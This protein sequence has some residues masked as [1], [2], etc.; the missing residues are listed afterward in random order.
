MVLAHPGGDE[1]DQRQPEQQVQV[2]PQDPAVDVAGGVQQVVVVVPVDAEVD[3]AQHVAQEH[4]RERAQ[5]GEVGAVRHLQLEHH[6]RDDDG[7]DA[8]A[9][10]LQPSL[11][12]ADHPT[13]GAALSFHRL[14]LGGPRGQRLVVRERGDAY[15]PGLRGEDEAATVPDRRV[16][17]PGVRRQPG[18][19]GAA[20]GL[21]GRHDAAG[22]RGR[23]QPRGD[24]LP[25]GQQR[26]V[27]DP[28]DDAHAGGR[29]VRA[30]DARFRL[31]RDE[32]ADPG[33]REVAFRSKSGPLLVAARGERLALDFPSRPGSQRT[34]NRACSRTPLGAPRPSCCAP[35]TTWRCSRPSMKN[36][37]RI[38]KKDFSF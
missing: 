17:E 11:G 5:R 22:D 6:D 26:R 34:P 19:R 14:D 7:D 13:S 1:R 9:E 16:R 18:G 28:L 10:G 25:G 4:R 29:P 31:G 24:R 35:A 20:R 2:G 12:H 30:R 23:E 33:R 37:R 36:S 27:R 21:A 32:R 3:E 8:V 38:D 15:S